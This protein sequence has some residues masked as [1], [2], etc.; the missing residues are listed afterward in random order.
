MTV[1][2][3]VIFFV[4]HSTQKQFAISRTGA[5]TLVLVNHEKVTEKESSVNGMPY[6]S[7]MTLGVSGNGGTGEGVAEKFSPV[8]K[9]CPMT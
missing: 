3:I 5:N 7:K 1:P 9:A 2:A 6:R 4:G 8:F